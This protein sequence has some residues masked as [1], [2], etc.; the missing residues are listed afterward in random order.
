MAQLAVTAGDWVRAFSLAR[1]HEECRRDV[2]L[3]HAHRMARE[4]KFVEAQKGNFKPLK[5]TIDTAFYTI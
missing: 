5:I 4:N 1:E 3:P 2:Y